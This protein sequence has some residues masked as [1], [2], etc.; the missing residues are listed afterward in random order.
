MSRATSVALCAIAGGIGMVRFPCPAAAHEILRSISDGKAV[1]IELSHPHATC[2]ASES[3]EIFRPDETVAFQVGRTDQHGRI[4]FIPDRP[5]AWRVRAF[6]ED[7]HGANFT[8]DADT[9]S[10]AVKADGG[11]STPDRVSRM[12]GGVGALLG[13]FGAWSLFRSRR[14]ASSSRPLPS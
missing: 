7:G 1:V 8:V 14:S 9:P 13:L 12:V 3:Y 2:F 4:V 11:E 10:L 6:T 5:G